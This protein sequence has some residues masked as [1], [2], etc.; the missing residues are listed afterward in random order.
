LTFS[1]MV[2]GTVAGQST[3]VTWSVQ[4]A[5]GGTVDGSGHYTAP[6]SAGTFHVIATSVADPTKK[7]SATVTVTSIAVAISPKT[8]ATITGGALTFTATVTGTVAGQATGVTWSVQE[9]GGGTVDSSGHHT[10]PAPPRPLPPD[11]HQRGGSHQE[12]HRHQHGDDDR[13]RDRTED[14]I[15]TDRRSARLLRHGDG[16]DRRSGD[17][18]HLVGAGGRRR[19]GGHLGPLHGSRFR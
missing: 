13:R 17:R 2:T 15:G 16:H 11:R 6:A 3:A 9:A 7:G 5:G 12:G 14:G 4:E 8:A 18:R 19:N 1:A 10:P